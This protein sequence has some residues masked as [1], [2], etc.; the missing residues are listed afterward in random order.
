M[1]L[2]SLEAFGTMGKINVIAEKAGC[3]TATVSR[4]INGCKNGF[5]VRKEL[6]ALILRLA[7]EHDYAPNPFFRS[8]RAKK[9]KLAAILDNSY[10][11]PG[12]AED[13]KRSFVYSIRECGLTEALKFAEPGKPETYKLQFPVDAALL[14]DVMDKSCLDYFE[15]HAIPYAV[16]NGLCG[17]GGASLMVDEAK[18]AS[19][20]LDHLLSLGHT[21]IAYANVRRSNRSDAAPE[22]CSVSQRESLY[23]SFMESHGLEPLPTHSIKNLPP[24]ELLGKALDCGAT[25]VLC[26]HHWQATPLIQSAWRRGLKL[27]D[28]LSVAC[29]NDGYPLPYLTPS[30]TC[31][32]TPGE[33]MGVEA[34]KLIAGFLDGSL[35][36]SG[37]TIVLSGELVVR[38][39]TAQLGKEPRHV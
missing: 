32:S 15:S 31:V 29:F 30:V 23:L 35:R 39:S 3:S 24:E 38:E 13:A 21:R 37:Q 28:D 11:G 7:K 19:L 34:A 22:H 9:T 25:A 18:A 20:I 33:Q 8:M 6:E 17:P 10:F 2:C 27:P 4:V 26:Y 1:G 36:P 5:S 12:I 16:C 14:F